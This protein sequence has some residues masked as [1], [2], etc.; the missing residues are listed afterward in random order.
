MKLSRLIVSDWFVLCGIGAL[1]SGMFVIYNQAS[2]GAYTR[3]ANASPLPMARRRMPP[4]IHKSRRRR[5][6]ASA[7]HAGLHSSLWPTSVPNWQMPSRP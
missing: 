2:S 7:R 3:T 1:I 6:D 4:Q 5:R